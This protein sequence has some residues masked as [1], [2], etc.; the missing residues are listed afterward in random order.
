MGLYEATTRNSQ[1]LKQMSRELD[2][3]VLVLSQLSRAVE[4]RNDKY[5]ML[6]DLRDSGAIEQDADAVFGLYRDAYYALQEEPDCNPGEPEYIEWQ[7]RK[8]SRELDVGILKQ[9][10][11]ETGPVTLYCDPATGIIQ[12]IDR[13]DVA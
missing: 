4:Q 11:G 10:G 3:P 13:R 8:A 9:R 2:L 7:E 6:S 5:P 1:A 12:D